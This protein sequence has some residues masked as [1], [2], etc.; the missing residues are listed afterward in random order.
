MVIIPLLHYDKI[1]YFLF[2]TPKYF[3][4]FVIFVGTTHLFPERFYETIFQL[5]LFKRYSLMLIIL[6]YSTLMGLLF[7]LGFVLFLKISYLT[8]KALVN[9]F[10]GFQSRQLRVTFIINI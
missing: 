5:K 9:K 4:R 1:N 2:R 6:F 3:L 10:R 8:P 7:E